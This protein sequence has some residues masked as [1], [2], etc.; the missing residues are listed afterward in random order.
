MQEFVF[1][2]VVSFA[3]GLKCSATFAAVSVEYLF[4]FRVI[5][6]VLHC[7]FNL[8]SFLHI[9]PLDS[10]DLRSLML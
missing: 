1:T 4:S 7:I 8:Q 3:I 2:S 10:S 9:C 5:A 6:Y